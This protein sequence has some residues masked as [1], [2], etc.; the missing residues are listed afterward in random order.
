MNAIQKAVAACGGQ[1][2]LADLLGV[3]QSAVNQWVNGVRPVP[4]TRCR[5]IESAAG[6]E[7]TCHDLRPDVFGFEAA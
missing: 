5:A 2:A 3:S 7:V 1:K 6:G 4:P